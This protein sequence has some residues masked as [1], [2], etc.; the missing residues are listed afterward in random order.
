MSQWFH[1]T[2]GVAGAVAA[3]LL[4]TATGAQDPRA[5]N[6]TTRFD[7]YGNA[8]WNSNRWGSTA[9][10]LE[11]PAGAAPWD[12]V[13][14]SA[15]AAAPGLGFATPQVPARSAGGLFDRLPPLASP[16]A[17]GAEAPALPIASS[18]DVTRQRV[19]A[20]ARFIMAARSPLLAE[21]GDVSSGGDDAVDPPSSVVTSGTGRFL[22]QQSAALYQRTRAAGWTAFGQADY[23]GASYQLQT[24][25]SLSPA[26]RVAR[27][28]MLF[29][30][31]GLERFT[32]AQTRM[33]RSVR[34][35]GQEALTRSVAYG[36]QFASAEEYVRVS[37]QLQRHVAAR[38]GDLDAAALLAFFL[39]HAGG[40]SDALRVAD[41]IARQRPE[42][43]YAAWA[44]TMRSAARTPAA[45]A[46][47]SA[48]AVESAQP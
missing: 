5:Y 33:A 46:A 20:T 4:T 31:V 2:P 36:A 29:C 38:P 21:S 43:P 8:R 9:Y 10:G 12:Y 16:A 7:E 22:R 17:A 32:A 11:P 1:P 27:L 34:Q 47:P 42:S 37:T 39:W 28:G 25:L 30:D 41:Q 26:D 6:F 13:S 44:A 15:P 45:P 48:P 35:E 24:A 14:L 40:D 19:L 18:I 3:L 23:S